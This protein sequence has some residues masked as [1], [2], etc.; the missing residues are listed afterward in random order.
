MD[1]PLLTQ[2]LQPVWWAADPQTSNAW[3]WPCCCLLSGPPLLHVLALLLPLLL[4]LLLLVGVPQL[5]C[6]HVFSVSIC[7]QQLLL[8]HFLVAPILGCRV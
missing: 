2:Q 4:L 3:T 6:W 5:L 7:L 1:H 8:L